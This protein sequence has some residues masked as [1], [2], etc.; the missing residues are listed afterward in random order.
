MTHI[1][2]SGFTQPLRRMPEITVKAQKLARNIHGENCH[3][4]ACDYDDMAY[5][6]FN[7]ITQEFE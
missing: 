7:N 2:T 4:T 1:D 3:C 6:D 5:G